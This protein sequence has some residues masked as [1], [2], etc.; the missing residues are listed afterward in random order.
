M[1]GSKMARSVHE[2][3]LLDRN[4]MTDMPKANRDIIGFDEANTRQHWQRNRFEHSQS[5]S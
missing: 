4:K 3:G 2:L 5:I 1:D